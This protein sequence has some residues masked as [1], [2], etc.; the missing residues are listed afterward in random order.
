MKVKL[1]TRAERIKDL[2]AFLQERYRGC[3]AFN[4][5]NTACDHMETI[6]ID[7]DI[8][9]DFCSQFGYIEIFGLTDREYNDLIRAGS[10]HRLTYFRTKGS[11]EKAREQ[12]FVPAYS[13]TIYVR[14]TFESGA[15]VKYRAT[16][17]DIM[18]INP[19][20]A[21]DLDVC[22]VGEIKGGRE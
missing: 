19:E 9:V 1:R 8:T 5:R 3:Q 2:K 11:C 12:L 4:C 14:K 18:R 15:C 17:Q 16:P 20:L 21:G 22:G 7:G 13:T 10:L 6:Y